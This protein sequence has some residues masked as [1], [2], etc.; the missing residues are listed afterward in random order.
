[1]FGIACWPTHRVSSM[2]VSI[3]VGLVCWPNYSSWHSLVVDS[4]SLATAFLP[5]HFYWNFLMDS[6]APMHYDLCSIVAAADDV[7]ATAAATVAISTSQ[8]VV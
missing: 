4:L 6:F 2:T 3:S 8:Q 1:M 5:R 7:C